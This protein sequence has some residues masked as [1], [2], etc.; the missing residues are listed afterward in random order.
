MSATVTAAAEHASHI[1]MVKVKVVCD[2]SYP[3]GG[4][5]VSSVL[6]GLGANAIFGLAQMR[7]TTGTQLV[8]IFRADAQKVALYESTTG[9]PKALVECASSS[10]DVSSSTIIDLL[11]V[12]FNGMGATN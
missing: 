1:K 7:Y 9:A 11:L 2:S 4:Y 8:P 10:G 5:D 3:T 6:T 12:V